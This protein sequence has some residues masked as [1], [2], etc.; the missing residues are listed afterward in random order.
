MPFSREIK[1]TIALVLTAA[2]ACCMI[3]GGCSQQMGAQSSEQEESGP[4]SRSYMAD[5][6]E[7]SDA[8]KEK[9]ASFS[10]AV[11]REDLV[12]MRVQAD[13]ITS[14]IDQ[15]SQMEAPDELS[16]LKQKYVDACTQLKDALIAYIDLYAEIDSSTVRNPF[17]YDGYADRIGAIQA[18]YDAAVQALQDADK[19]A[20][21]M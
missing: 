19:S 21:E 5:M 6:N 1:R 15:M 3:L 7:A 14:V 17:D 16:D 20:T 13:G 8:L 10:D 9:M 12:S 4:T 11:A 2:L 18:Q